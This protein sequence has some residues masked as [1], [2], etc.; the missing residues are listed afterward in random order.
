MALR[1]ELREQGDLLFRYR[2]YLPVVIVLPA[3]YL[4]V[5]QGSGLVPEA[6]RSAYELG[7]LVV[8]LV[9]ELVRIKAVGHSADNT[10][11]RNTTEGQLAD[12]INTTG[13]YSTLRHPLY[14]GN[15]LMWLGLAGLTQ[16]VWFMVAFTGLYW[17]YYERIMFAEEEFL[18]GKFGNAYLEWS[19]RTPAFV[20]K[21][22]QWV[23]P[24]LAFSWPKVIRQEKAS[25]L[26]L[27]LVFAAFEAIRSWYLTGTVHMENVWIYGLGV[28]AGWYIMVKAVQ[29]TTGLLSKDR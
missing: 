3:L 2:S 9:G 26:N 17:I 20:P 7:C 29:L 4:Y 16:N 1:H 11:G 13:L 24:K 5:L 23:K 10:S 27:F 6:Y 22:S 12:S 18:I 14:L 25:I 19:K 8:A 15:Y 21:L 28:A